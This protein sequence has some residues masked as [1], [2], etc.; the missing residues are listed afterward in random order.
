MFEKYRIPRVYLLDGAGGIDSDGNY[1]SP[2]RDPTKRF[3]ASLG[4]IIRHYE[5][6]KLNEVIQV[7]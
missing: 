7:Y 4:N 6:F 1:V 3:G 2:Y 5:D